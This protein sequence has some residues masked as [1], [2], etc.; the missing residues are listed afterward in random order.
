MRIT[1]DAPEDRLFTSGVSQGVLFPGDA[2]G[3]AW[4]GLISV[5]E[6]SDSTKD[7]KYFDGIKYRERNVPSPFTGTIS[8]F[9]YPDELEPYVGIIET[10]TGQPRTAFGFS[11]RTEHEIHIVYNV[12]ALPTKADYDTVSD[13]TNPVAFEWPFTTLPE[14]IPGGKPTAHLVVTVDYAQPGAIDA[15]EAFIYGDDANEPSLPEPDD[16]IDLFEANALM[17]VIDNGDN[18]FTVIG[19]DDMVSMVDAD[20]F[21]ITADTVV[22][23]P[24]GTFRVSSQ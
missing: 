5:T 20:T 2:P 23:F 14:K 21:R 1:W 7:P 8:A 11:Y 15:L 16:L 22:I 18:T 19:P 13:K 17:Q 12:L 4:N 10:A 9:T 24:D 6:V 3:V